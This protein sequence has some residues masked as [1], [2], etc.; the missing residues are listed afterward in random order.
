MFDYCAFFFEEPPTV[1]RFVA[2]ALII[3]EM[4]FADP[5]GFD[6]DFEKLMVADSLVCFFAF[7]GWV[8]DRVTQQLD[9]FQEI[10][11]RRQRYA[12]RRGMTAP[13]VFVL[14]CY[15]HPDKL[16]VNRI[17]PPHAGLPGKPAP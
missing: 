1:P 6:Y 4:E 15:F 16:F 11:E 13:P 17:V 5:N 9:R 7:Y 10:A 12:E 8:K 2:Q 3:G 14:S